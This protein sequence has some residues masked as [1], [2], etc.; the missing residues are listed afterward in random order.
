MKK[1]IYIFICLT[2][3]CTGSTYAQKPKR[4]NIHLKCGCQIYSIERKCGL[5]G[6]FLSCGT[7]I[8][9]VEDGPYPYSSNYKCSNCGHHHERLRNEYDYNRPEHKCSEQC[10][11]KKENTKPDG[12]KTLTVHNICSEK[13]NIGFY[14][15][16]EANFN[17][18]I[19][20]YGET[21]TFNASPG[22][23]IDIKLV[24]FRETTQ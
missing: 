1:T 7:P 5:C 16:A 21:A 24:K 6:G 17:P 4:K 20:R 19:L 9:N 23:S 8:I 15:A 13:R 18:R 14:N 3:L 22:H 11:D 10:I 2:I 12:S